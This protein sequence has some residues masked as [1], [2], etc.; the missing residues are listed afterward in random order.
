MGT[1]QLS[2]FVS[3]IPFPKCNYKWNWSNLCVSSE[4]VVDILELLGC[5]TLSSDHQSLV[6][7]KLSYYHC[8]LRKILNFTTFHGIFSREN[9]NSLR[10][11]TF[12]I[13]TISF[14]YWISSLLRG[15]FL[16]YELNTCGIRTLYSMAW[17][18]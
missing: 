12:I 16:F 4:S 6:L 9:V 10:W 8:I 15:S 3:I 7:K 17:K 13:S 5:I 14:V 18:E 2:I 11:I 1:K